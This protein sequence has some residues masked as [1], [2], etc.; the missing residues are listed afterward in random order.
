MY[1]APNYR[2]IYGNLGP[3]VNTTIGQTGN[4]PLSFDRAQSTLLFIESQIQAQTGNVNFRLGNR[5]TVGGNGAA[6]PQFTNLQVRNKVH[7]TEPFRLILA[8]KI[9]ERSFTVLYNSIL[10]LLMYQGEG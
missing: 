4:V 7:Q 5:A 6:N 3:Q 8:M 9:S 1:P 2:T 10:V